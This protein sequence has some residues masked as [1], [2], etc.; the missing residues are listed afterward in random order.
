MK[1]NEAIVIFSLIAIMV[2]VLVVVIAVKNKKTDDQNQLANNPTNVQNQAVEEFVEKMD[3]GT[4]VNTSSKLAETKRYDVYEVSNI[5]LVEK[6]N[7]S[8][9]RA[10]VKNTSS[11]VRG[12]QDIYL[13][14]VDKNGATITKI[15][16]YLDTLQ[17][18]ASATLSIDTSADFANAYDY[19]IS[20]TK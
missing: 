14:F 2:I 15:H 20:L 8:S 1:K 10:T 5:T 13:E 18:G 12:D 7:L 4:R 17:P 16:G 9:V 11:S 6:G 3:D 19:K